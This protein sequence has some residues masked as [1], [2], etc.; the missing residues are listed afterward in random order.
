M[1]VISLALMHLT[2]PDD[3]EEEALVLAKSAIDLFFSTVFHI[4]I[5][6]LLSSC[7]IG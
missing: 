6:R 7:Y 2:S 4:C 5:I 1:R 3:A